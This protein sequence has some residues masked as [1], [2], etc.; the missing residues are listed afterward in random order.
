MNEQAAYV[1]RWRADHPGMSWVD[2]WTCPLCG[3]TVSQPADVAYDVFTDFIAWHKQNH[4]D[5]WRAYEAAAA[6]SQAAE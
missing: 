6:P 1:E 5:D 2:R 3:N 4:G